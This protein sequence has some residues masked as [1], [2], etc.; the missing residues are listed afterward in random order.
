MRIFSPNYSGA[1][2]HMGIVS[3]NGWFRLNESDYK[4]I[5]LQKTGTIHEVLY[6]MEIDNYNLNL[7][8]SI[9]V[10]GRN[11][12]NHLFSNTEKN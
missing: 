4:I 10:Y 9:Q 6:R 11:Y 8:D 12:M 3:S 2:I 1:T 7:L 5:L